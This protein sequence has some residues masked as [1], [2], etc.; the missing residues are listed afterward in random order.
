MDWKL[1]EWKVKEEEVFA[2]AREGRKHLPLLFLKI[3]LR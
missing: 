2:R 3:H 1:R